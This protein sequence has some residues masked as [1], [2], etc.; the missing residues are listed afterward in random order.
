MHDTYTLLR[1]FADSW[2]LLAAVRLLRRAHPLGV[3]PRQPAR[4]TT[5]PRGRSSARRPTAP[6][7]ATGRGGRDERQARS[8]RMTD[9]V[10]GTSDHRP[11][12]GRHRGAEQPAAALVALDLLRHHSVGDRLHDPLPGLAAGR[13]RHGRRPGLVDAR[14]RWRPRSRAVDASQ[15][16]TARRR[17]WTTDLARAAAERGAERLC[18]AAR[19]RRC[20]ATTARSATAR[21]RRGRSA[22]RTCWT[23]TGSGAAASRTSPTTIRH[24]IRNEEDPDARFSQMPAFGEM[25]SRQEIATLVAHVQ[26]LPGGA[27]PLAGEGGALFADNC[28]ACHGEDAPRQPRHRRAEPDRR[29]LAL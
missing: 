22:I 27:D 18:R 15:A 3:P 13:R 26:S 29:D 10:T 5:T 17:W 25:L 6:P 2:V 28:A 21:A 4:C 8:S 12:L 23:T 14:P 7:T 20:S 11:Q 24:G 19:G 9:P 1:H 16:A